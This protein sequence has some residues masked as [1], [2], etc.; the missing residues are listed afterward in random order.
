MTDTIS[1]AA[2]AEAAPYLLR[3]L[4]AQVTI[5]YHPAGG[6]VSDTGRISYINNFWLELTKDN[7]DVLLMPTSAI[8]LIKV[9]QL[10]KLSGEAGILLRA[11][12]PL[13]EEQRKQITRE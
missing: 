12:E 4:S 9:L 1:G 13:P 5:Y 6:G 7:G 8:R 10:N 11:A 3:Y 2:S